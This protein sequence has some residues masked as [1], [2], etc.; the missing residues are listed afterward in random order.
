M[1]RS[2][3]DVNDSVIDEFILCGQFISNA[4]DP[5]MVCEYSLVTGMTYFFRSIPYIEQLRTQSCYSSRSGRK[6][7][8]NSLFP[9]FIVACLNSTPP[10]AYPRRSCNLNLNKNLACR[11]TSLGLPLK[12]CRIMPTAS[13]SSH[14]H[15]RQIITKLT[16]L[17]PDFSR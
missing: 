17:V 16:H 1:A 13:R 5:E 11:V 2:L 14:C 7:V 3:R 9:T 6:V 4:D 15:F 12:S 10:A 8:R